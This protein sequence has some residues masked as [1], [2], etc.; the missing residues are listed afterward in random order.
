VPIKKP[1]VRG[2]EFRDG[3]VGMLFSINGFPRR[4]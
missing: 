1:K 4:G 2:D 3:A